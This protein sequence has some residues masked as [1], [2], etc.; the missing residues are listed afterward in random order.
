MVFKL[1]LFFNKICFSF[2]WMQ[3]NVVYVNPYI[4]TLVKGSKANSFNDNP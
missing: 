3:D 2:I 4:L 1:Q